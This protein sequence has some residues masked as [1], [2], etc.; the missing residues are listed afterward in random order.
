MNLRAHTAGSPGSVTDPVLG[1]VRRSAHFLGRGLVLG[2]LFGPVFGLILALAWGGTSAWAQTPEPTAAGD[3]GEGRTALLLFMSRVQQTPVPLEPARIRHTCTAGLAEHLQSIGHDVVDPADLQPLVERWR[4]RSDLALSEGFLR[5]C[6]DKLGTRQLIVARLLIGP[7]QVAF[8]CRALNTPYGVLTGVRTAV[9]ELPAAGMDE[10][11][12][13]ATAWLDCLGTLCRTPDLPASPVP[14]WAARNLVVLPTAGIGCDRAAADLATQALLGFLLENQPLPIIDPGHA[15]ATLLAAGLAPRKF[16]EA[17]R[18]LL[19]D[20]FHA[21]T[22]L[23]SD[24]I[25]Y[26]LA[27]GGAT[28]A[29]ARG[30]GDGSAESLLAAFSL[31]LRETDLATGSIA[32]GASVFRDHT[33]PAGWFGRLHTESLV[34]HLAEAVATLWLSL[35]PE[36]K[37]S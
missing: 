21:G 12:P 35:H 30:E 26:T 2:P 22:V 3:G 24:L 18:T 17:G 7:R 8:L 25:S 37:E 23:N 9:T 1:R 15:T 10:A 20:R 33:E 34:D 16:G 4:V 36:P 31:T 14:V 29:G 13:S 5:D 11:E 32:R 6:R 19:A 28:P 27:G